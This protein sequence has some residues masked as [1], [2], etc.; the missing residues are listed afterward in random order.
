MPELVLHRTAASPGDSQTAEPAADAAA[1]AETGRQDLS[2][3]TSLPDV[4]I[5]E[6]LTR[7]PVAVPQPGSCA[8]WPAGL[9]SLPW[10]TRVAKRVLDISGAALLLCLTSPLLLLAAVAVRL[11][12]PGPVF[13]L[14]TRVGLNLR[15][16]MAGSV[17]PRTGDACR[18][19]RANYGRPFT[20]YKLRTM[21]HVA[22]GQVPRQAV[23]ADQRVTPVGRFL[24]RSRIDELPQLLNVLRGEMSLVGP[25]PECIEYLDALIQ[26]I[27][28][29]PQRLQLRPGLTGMAQIQSGYANDA[30]SYQ[31][32]VAWDLL[33]LQHCSVTNDLRILFRTVR[34]VLTGFGAV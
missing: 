18:R 30:A 28:D 23:A 10:R 8:R 21:Y 11:T 6:W 22:A 19:R 33:Y 14:Q 27:P 34:V 24:R 13:F 29:Y 32:K 3:A 4:P 15:R 5:P 1:A 26:Q 16:S 20:I 31:R 2:A 9:R 17:E 7:R 12:S 25:R